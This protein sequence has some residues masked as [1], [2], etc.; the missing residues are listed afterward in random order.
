FEVSARAGLCSQE[1]PSRVRAHLKAMGMKTDLRD[2]PG[3][4]PD[5]DGLLDLMGQDKKVVDGALRYIM[6]RGIGEAFVTSDIPRDVVHGVLRDAL[7]D[8]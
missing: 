5:A 2:I 6:V 7:S 8:R 4:L 3:E 1:D